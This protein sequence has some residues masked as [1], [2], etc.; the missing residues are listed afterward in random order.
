MSTFIF[1]VFFDKASIKAGVGHL[2]NVNRGSSWQYRN[3]SHR[4]QQREMEPEE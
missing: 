1:G 4:L 3:S 2:G